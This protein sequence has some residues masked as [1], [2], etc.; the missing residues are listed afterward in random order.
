MKKGLLCIMLLIIIDLTCFAQVQFEKGYFVDNEG[1]RTECLIKNYGWNCNPSSFEYKL[2]EHSELLSSSARN[3]KE[4]GFGDY[5]KYISCE[6]D[7]DRSGDIDANLSDIRRPVFNNEVLF[8]KQIVSGKANLYL[9]KEEFITR[10][11][12]N[13]ND[14]KIKQLVYKRYRISATSIAKNLQYIQQL[15]TE[16]KYEGY[17]VFKLKKIRYSETALTRYFILYNGTTGQV[18]RVIKDARSKGSYNLSVK[19]GMDIN[20]LSIK[21]AVDRKYELSSSSLIEVVTESVLNSNAEN[22]VGYHAGVEL[23]YILPFNR[24]KFAVLI[25][26]SY[27]MYKAKA[28][29]SEKPTYYYKHPPKYDIQVD[30]FEL[31]AGARYY[32]FLNKKSKIYIDA[33]YDFSSLF[34]SKNDFEDNVLNVSPLYNLYFNLGYTYNDRF[35]AELKYTIS[36]A[37]IPENIDLLVHSFGFCIAY[38]F[39][40]SKK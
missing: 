36:E 31:V 6:V 19:F 10:F 37:P 1:G 2:S 8:L 30:D 28:V 23:E 26:P 3:V 7:I 18:S 20:N 5:L 4:F 16:L 21:N 32:M 38:K 39:F 9:Y 35:S 27:R 12:Y 11:F 40:N 34:K 33:A 14:S 15:Y 24:N 29:L 22:V 25:M 17:S 13:V